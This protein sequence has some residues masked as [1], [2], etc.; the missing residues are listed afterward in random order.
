MAGCPKSLRNMNN[1]TLFI[2][3]ELCY[4]VTRASLRFDNSDSIS[5]F[6]INKRDF[7]PQSNQL[8]RDPHFRC[9]PLVPS[10]ICK[11]RIS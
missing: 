9:L 1:A 8:L 5:R 3:L 6:S 10:F 2:K 11:V 4:Y 7:W